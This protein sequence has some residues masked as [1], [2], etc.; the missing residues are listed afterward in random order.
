M[1]ATMPSNWNINAVHQPCGD[2]TFADTLAIIDIF[3]SL[4]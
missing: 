3:P 1:S 2:A 4:V